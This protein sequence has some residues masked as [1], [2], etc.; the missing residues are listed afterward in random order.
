MERVRRTARSRPGARRNHPDGFRSDAGAN[1]MDTEFLTHEELA[2][3]TSTH[4]GERLTYIM[5]AIDSMMLGA[6]QRRSLAI[7]TWRLASGSFSFGTS[8]SSRRAMT[9]RSVMPVR[10]W[11]R[12]NGH[13]EACLSEKGGEGTPVEVTPAAET[14]PRLS[15]CKFASCCFFWW[16]VCDS[17][18]RP[19]D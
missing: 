12:R 7:Q 2:E 1:V 3:L 13:H 10:C 6:R 8:G 15:Y 4:R 14:F 5:G 11:A 19:T 17:N 16:V 18:A 9:I